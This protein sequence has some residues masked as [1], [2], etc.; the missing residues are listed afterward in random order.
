[1]K[2]RLKR[3]DFISDLSITESVE[4]TE[5]DRTFQSLWQAT[6]KTGHSVPLR[7][8]KQQESKHLMS[9]VTLSQQPDEL[10][11]TILTARVFR[12]IFERLCLPERLNKRV[13]RTGTRSKHLKYQLLTK[14]EGIALDT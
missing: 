10:G 13:N 3:Q 11:Y 5:A 2:D 7:L 9:W 14:A 1:M 6:K 12:S 8:G 4:C